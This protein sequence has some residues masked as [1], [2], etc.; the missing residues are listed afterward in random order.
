MCSIENY[1]PTLKTSPFSSFQHLYKFYCDTKEKLLLHLETFM[2]EAL[3]LS[4]SQ[5]Y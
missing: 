5:N 1:I 2:T 3:V 4:L